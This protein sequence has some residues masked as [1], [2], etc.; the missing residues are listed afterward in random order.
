MFRKELLDTLK[1]I[2]GILLVV[3]GVTLFSF[4]VVRY[5]F[6]F[7]LKFQEIF[8]PITWAAMILIA[9]F[10]GSS[11][12]SKERNG[13]VFEYFF[14]LPGIRW[15]ALF[16]KVFPRF[17]AFLACFQLHFIF[18]GIIYKTPYPSIRPGIFFLLLFF[19][20]LFSVSKSLIY[21]KGYAILIA[22][23]FEFSF[24]FIVIWILSRVLEIHDEQ[25]ILDYVTAIFGMIA[26]TLFIVFA[27]RFK[28]ID[29]SNMFRLSRKNIFQ[30]MLPVAV[31]LFLF[32]FVNQVDTS[33]PANMFSQADLL[34]V[35]FDKSN[36]FY[37]LWSLA[38][39]TEEDV[40][41]ET[42][43]N[44]YRR[45]FDPK[46]DNERFIKKFDY[47]AYKQT[48]GEMTN[49]IKLN[50]G[51]TRGIRTDI[52]QYLSSSETNLENIE[53][54]HRILLD[55]YRELVN[56][57]II[58]DFSSIRQWN[59]PTFNHLAWLKIAKLFIAVNAKNAVDGQWEE[60]VSNLVAHVV[61]SRKVVNGSRITITNL[62][63][64]AVARF[65]LEMLVALMNRDDCPQEVYKLILEGLPPLKP[66]DFGTK[67]SCIFEA[68]MFDQ[69]LD[70]AIYNEIQEKGDFFQQMA[71]HLFTQKNRTVKKFYQYTTELIDF[72]TTL[73]YRWKRE[74]PNDSERKQAFWW[75]F[76]PGG[77]QILNEWKVNYHSILYK[78]FQTKTLYDMTRI[79]AQLYFKGVSGKPIEEVLKQLDTYK[80]TIDPCSG[81]PYA[82][83]SQKQVLYSLGTDR[84]DDNGRYD[85]S[86]LDTDFAIPLRIKTKE[87]VPLL[88]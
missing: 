32:V 54:E 62:L 2:A 17:L 52:W 41:S 45:L 51:A 30:V 74:I 29:M 61:F 43:I 55:R 66:G 23:I 78:T 8:L 85:S 3:L 88:P 13:N 49:K 81:K 65:S 24:I 16:F 22:N 19:V 31:F 35:S 38:E 14:S 12:F 21:Q 80:K 71:Y 50:I 58:E 28:V 37:R 67:N 20:F 47:R 27:V 6:G 4:F 86:T 83:N 36:G 73:P 33:K 77:Q 75:F 7:N 69:F 53:Q 34:P 60:G 72:E 56:T 44:K 42:V 59:Q 18:N 84:D 15:K 70:K 11:I 64:K 63:G 1:S 76:N 40:E 39:S 46:Y 26:L 48:T 87:L 10:L 79:C 25:V 9:F 68:L 82:W 5:I 57:E